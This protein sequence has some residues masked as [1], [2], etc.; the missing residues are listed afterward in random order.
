MRFTGSLGEPL[1]QALNAPTWPY[2]RLTPNMHKTRTRIYDELT[3][4]KTLDAASPISPRMPQVR[5]SD[6]KISNCAQKTSL[7]VARLLP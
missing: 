5:R 6:V 3:E 7:R 1:S 4:S 2:T